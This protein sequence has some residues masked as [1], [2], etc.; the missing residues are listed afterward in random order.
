[1]L[2]RL[3]GHTSAVEAVT[4]DGNEATV[5]GGSASG[6]LKLWDLS[7]GKSKSQSSSDVLFYI[8]Y[9]C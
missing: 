4:F 2:H 5:V 1:M 7:T 6:T 3:T 8:T 9:T